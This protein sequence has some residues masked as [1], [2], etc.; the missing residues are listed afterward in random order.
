MSPGSQ[1]PLHLTRHGTKPT[2]APPARARWQDSRP[3]GEEAVLRDD[4]LTSFEHSRGLFQQTLSDH[5]RSMTSQHQ[6]ALREI[7]SAYKNTP[8]IDSA[9]KNTPTDDYACRNMPTTSKHNTGSAYKSSPTSTANI[10]MVPPS[11]DRNV[12]ISGAVQGKVVENSMAGGVPS[13]VEKYVV[14]NHAGNVSQNSSGVVVQSL[15]SGGGFISP[16][17]IMSVDSLTTIP[18]DSCHVRGSVVRNLE[19]R[20]SPMANGGQNT[21]VSLERHQLDG[22]GNLESRKSGKV[23][24]CPD[25]SSLSASPGREASPLPG[26]TEKPGCDQISGTIQTSGVWTVGS[27]SPEGGRPVSHCDGTHPAY[28]QEA[29][30]SEASDLN[31]GEQSGGKVYGDQCR[32]VFQ[33]E[34]APVDPGRI[35]TSRIETDAS[36]RNG[37]PENGAGQQEAPVKANVPNTSRWNGKPGNGTGVDGCGSLSGTTAADRGRHEAPKPQADVPKTSGKDGSGNGVDLNGEVVGL[38]PDHNQTEVNL[39]GCNSGKGGGAGENGIVSQNESVPVDPGGFGTRNGVPGNGAGLSSF[40]LHRNVTSPPNI[41]IVQPSVHHAVPQSTTVD[42][43]IDNP[44]TQPSLVGTGPIDSLPAQ[45]RYVSG[46]TVKTYPGGTVLENHQPVVSTLF[47]SSGAPAPP[48]TMTVLP[49]ENGNGHLLP[50]P[51]ETY[52]VSSLGEAATSSGTIFAIPPSYVTN[53]RMAEY[54]NRNLTSM[55]GFLG[56]KSPAL[57]FPTSMCIADDIAYEEI[58]VDDTSSVSSITSDVAAAARSV[59]PAG[60]QNLVDFCVIMSH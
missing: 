25:A 14:E 30:K 52:R 10:G 53:S 29:P 24:N 58:P 21:A 16:D 60:W 42:H 26:A 19:A 45:D 32:T 17:S 37:V 18:T 12:A 31:M 39:G 57:D 44:S 3:G 41:A 51:P 49:P 1:N 43:Y 22:V 7:D 47:S 59:A 5:Q 48:N 54:Q 11:A 56:G 8:T 13:T 34:S 38:Q 27:G 40:F 23:N 55:P 20:M 9:Y 50:E 15:S 35:G 46:C 33:N 6:R 4:S 28:H 2:S 36:G